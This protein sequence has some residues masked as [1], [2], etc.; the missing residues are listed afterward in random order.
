MTTAYIVAGPESSGNRLVA[1]I[2]ARSGC[3]GEGST[4]Q[5]LTPDDIPRASSQSVVVI[6]HRDLTDW[7]AGARRLGYGSVSVIVVIREPIA[8]VKSQVAR[9]HFADIATAHDSRT[10]TISDAINDTMSS[11]ADLH[12]IT[13]EGLTEDALR[14]WLPSI[15]LEYRNGPLELRGQDS[16]NWIRNSNGKHYGGGE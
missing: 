14:V 16:P 10:R 8:T 5:P 3:L 6:S 4:D 9:G 13:Y 11:G 1:A 15:G 12:V 7:I 2:L